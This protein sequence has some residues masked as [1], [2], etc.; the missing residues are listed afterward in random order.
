M[1]M[2]MMMTMMTMMTMNQTQRRRKKETVVRAD[3]IPIFKFQ[4]DH[5]ILRLRREG[6]RVN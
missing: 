1:T 5:V 3:Q 6:G 4:A 2:M